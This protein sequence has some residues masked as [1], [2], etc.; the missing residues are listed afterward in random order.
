MNKHSKRASAPDEIE[1]TAAMLAAG[2]RAL[3][4]CEDYP[5]TERHKVVE[6][7][8]AVYRTQARQRRARLR[9]V[10]PAEYREFLNK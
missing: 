2:V 4:G 7:L 5:S 10:F 3:E 9:I 6:V 1:I 8:K